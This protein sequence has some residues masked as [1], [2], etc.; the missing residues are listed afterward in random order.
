MERLVQAAVVGPAAAAALWLV[1][2]LVPRVW[3]RR[4]VGGLA[5][6]AAH[7]AAWA[8]LVKAF[9][10]EPAVWRSLESDLL[11]ASLAVVAGLAVLILAPRAESLPRARAPAAVVGLGVATSA[12]VAAAYAQSLVVQAIVLPIPTLAAAFGALSGGGRSDARGL[13]GLAAADGAALIGLVILVDRVGSTL[14]EP[15]GVGLGAGL[16]LGAAAAKMGAVPW[17]ATWRLAS[18]DGPGALVSIALRAQGVVLAALAAIRIGGTEV[19]APLAVGG[20]AAALAAGLAAVV[21][22]REAACVA[23]VAGAG[24]A[25]PMLGLG[26]GGA[27][28]IRAFL[29]LF[30][31]LLLGA[32]VLQALGW[33][34]DEEWRPVL[35]ARWAG[36]VTAGVAALTLTG[37][38]PGAGF[39]GGWL[40]LRLAHARADAEWWYLLVLGGAAL[41]LVLAAIAAVPLVRSV[42][43]R[44]VPA[45]LGAAATILFVYA[46]TQPLRLSLGWLVRIEQ[47]LGMPPLLPAAGAPALPPVGGWDLLMAAAPALVVALAMGVASR[48]ARGETLSFEPVATL[49]AWSAPA[50]LRA[51]G[52]GV[53]RAGLGFA[54]AFLLE[55]GALL[56]AG[57][58]VRE[59]I[60]LGFL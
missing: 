18:T 50:P 27:V 54:A 12:V 21:S 57:W 56:A 28:G 5:A 41:G 44:G 7:A 31:T 43:P 25:L 15:S 29:L 52:R 14:V 60:R 59:G 34:G 1:A 22:R 16:L 3:V 24:A 40:S 6:L 35:L 38:P 4:V 20:A 13:I 42:R 36:V 49:P 26:L 47:E 33:P 55:A 45:V 37:L 9:R 48:G 46:G 19:V 10:G 8:V 53:R 11:G 2:S 58:V 23:A 39:P 32:A 51:V 30:P 17:V